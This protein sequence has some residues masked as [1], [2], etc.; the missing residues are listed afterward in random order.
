MPRERNRDRPRPGYAPT[1]TSAILI[2][3]AAAVALLGHVRLKAELDRL[4]ADI[5]KLDR[6]VADTR[7]NN[8][9]LQIDYDTMTSP[10]G[11]SARIRELH[12]DLSMPLDDARIVL[13]EPTSE[14][15][16]PEPMSGL[17]DPRTPRFAIQGQGGGAAP[18]SKRP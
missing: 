7:R 13:P 6:Q 10:S 12:L 8:R 4:Y 3:L 1:V 14:P 2:C 18:G 16:L 15:P 11:L 5:T 17:I 9:K